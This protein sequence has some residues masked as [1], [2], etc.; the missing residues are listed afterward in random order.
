MSTM[1][2]GELFGRI[3][4]RATRSVAT[5]LNFAVLFSSTRAN[6]ASEWVYGIRLPDATI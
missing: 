4:Q 1:L 5:T 6:V 2:S 3:A